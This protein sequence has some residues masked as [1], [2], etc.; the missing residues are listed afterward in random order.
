[1]NKALFVLM[2]GDL[3]AACAAHALGSFLLYGAVVGE[4]PLHSPYQIVI[5][6]ATL[7]LTSYLAELYGWDRSNGRRE[8]VFRIGVSLVLAFFLLSGIY[9]LIPDITPDRTSLV[10]SLATFGFLQLIWHIG[11]FIFLR[12]PGIARK[13]L[14]FGFGPLADQIE[15]A[16]ATNP[17][18]YILAGSIRPSGVAATPGSVPTLGSMDGLA[19][20]AMRERVNTIVISVSERRGVLPVREILGCKLS[21]IEIVDDLSFYERITGKLLVERMHP[22]SL[23]FSSGLRVTPF[24]RFYKRVFD[25]IFASV[26]IVFASP[27]FPLIALAV[28]LDSPG[29]VLFRQNR[30]GKGEQVFTLY[31]FR[32]MRQ[33]AEKGTGAVWASEN[34]PRITRIG[35]FLRKSRLDEIPQLFNV[36]KGEM[37]FVGPRP[38][39]PEFV[40]TLKERIPYYSN[41]HSVKPGAT[42][43]AQVKYPYGASVE[44][45]IEK[46][47]YDLYYIKNYSLLLDFLIILETVKVVLFGRGAR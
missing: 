26:G 8:I 29:P 27:L 39:R 23:I 32:T 38:E 43:W 4:A 47:C 20:T 37:S 25:L 44:D 33:D 6:A 7:M 21:G 12:M 3:G 36:L 46:L 9:F 18:N 11:F 5:F 19:V 16:L 41:R 2:I 45:A 31:K 42:G 10:A 40:A 22:S 1:M 34:D 17:H 15:K 28:K 24:M 14:I 35:K 30:V 13:I